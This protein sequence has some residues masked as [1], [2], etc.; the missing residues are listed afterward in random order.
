METPEP[1]EPGTPV[2]VRFV[3]RASQSAGILESKGIVVRS[4]PG[5]GRMA[6]RFTGLASTDRE[7]IGSYLGS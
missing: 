2:E 4:N 3:V 7:A 1:P 6:V 5:L